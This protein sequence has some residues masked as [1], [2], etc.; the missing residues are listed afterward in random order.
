MLSTDIV[1]M[2][3][4]KGTRMKSQRPK[5][6][7]QLAGRPLLG[8]VLGSAVQLQPQP[9]SITVICG[10]GAAQVEQACRQLAAAHDGLPFNYVLQQPQR[11]TGH[12]MQQAAPVLPDDG[13]TLVLNG[14]V[15]LVR[16]QTMQRLRDAGAGGAVALL[17][18]DTGADAGAYGRIVRA[19]ARPDAPV[20]AIVEAR[21]AT[22]GQLALT[23]WY[24]GVMAAPTRL[25]KTYLA[26]LTNDNAQ[27]EFYLTDIVRHAVA[28]GTPVVAVTL[29][30][31]T[32]VAGVNSPLQLSALER[33]V[34]R[35]RAERLLAAGV[36]LADP[37]RFDLRDD[38]RSGT[39]ASLSCGQDVDIDVGCIFTGRVQ[40]GEG[41]R[42]G[43][44]CCIANATIAAGADIRPYTHIDGENKGVQVGEGA[45]VGPF[46]RLR[47]G[48]ELAANVH[49]GNFVEIKNSR[50][51]T[52]AKAN[53]LAYVGDAE[54][55]ER[56]NYGAGC[57][58]ANY[59]GAHKHRTIVEAD[60]HVGSNSVLVAPVV[61][62]AAG[63]VGA[64]S[65][66]TRDTPAGALTVA[67]ERQASKRDWSRP[68]KDTET[69]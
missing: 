21:D 41:A 63:T 65:V 27:Q 48:A 30:D 7:Q 15:P 55:G 1:I 67:R 8:H 61:I 5:V 39:P 18:V 29:D 58:T 17:T 11:G 9:R 43:A 12:A 35:A 26:K 20:Q 44:Y 28:D 31:A 22:P 19:S 51:A 23:E 68:R 14:D 47:P 38:A 64:G 45:Q 46:A 25:L 3:A 54:L 32:E 62:G 50:L 24:S 69:P 36:R 10:H 40:I 42:I 34:Q 56:V 66:I 60:V 6:L 57:I 33:A 16:P 37:A 2:A 49:V 4:G 53:H 59:D 52:G 13:L